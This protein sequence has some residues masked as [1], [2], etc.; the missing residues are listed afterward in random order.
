M[1][2]P[3]G[4]EIK[5]GIPIEQKETFFQEIEV[6]ELDASQLEKLLE[7]SGAKMKLLKEKGCW[8]WN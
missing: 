1:G 6:I 5:N 7:D 8:G 3:R 4:I 2:L